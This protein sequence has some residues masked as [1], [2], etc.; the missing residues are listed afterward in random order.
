MTLF[1]PQATPRVFVLPPG[2]DF[3]QALLDGLH[4]RL[5]GHGPEAL[6]RVEILVNTR[7]TQRRLQA[8]YETGPARLLPR[9]SVVT[10]LATDPGLALDLDAAPVSKLHRHLEL[11]RLITAMIEADPSLAERSAAYDLAGA[12]AALMD[13][14]QAG[15]LSWEALDRIDPGAHSAHW[16]RNLRFLALIRPFLAQ[17]AD[18][19]ARQRA[20]VEA[21]IAAWQAAPPAH[22][23]LV[24]GSTGSRPPTAMLMEAVAD[25]PQGAVIL[26]GFDTDLPAPVWEALGDD[27]APAA[28]DH[29]QFGFAALAGRIGFS[30][31]DLPLWHDTAPPAPSRNRLIS[32]SLRPAPVTHQWLADGPALVPALPEATEGLSLIEAADPRDEARAIAMRLRLALDEG[33][34]AALVSPDRNLTRRVTA[35]LDRWR[36]TPDDSAGRPLSL[37]P[38]GVFLR[39]VLAFASEIPTP[40]DLLALLKHPLTAG[41]DRG[42]HLGLTRALELTHLRGG[43]PFIDWAD[44]RRWAETRAADLPGAPAWIAWLADSLAPL[45]DPSP[46][47]L[48]AHLEAHIATAE[49][50]SRGMEDATAATLWDKTA[51]EE[52]RKAI[53]ELREAADAS[54]TIPVSDY[55]TILTALLA[56][57]VPAEP[58]TAHEGIAIWGTLEARTQSAAL[59]ILGGLNEA[60]WPRLPDPDPWLNRDMR[61]LIGLSAP[62]RRVGLSAHD[63]QQALGAQEVVLSRALRDD[64]APTVASRWW[65]RLTNLL[66]GLG[67]EGEAA[68]AAMRGRGEAL[69]AR[70]ARLDAPEALVP[71]APR[72]AP[73]PPLAAR[74]TR[75]SVTRIETL[76]RDPYQIYA[77]FILRLKP[78]DPPGRAPDA[79]ARG[80][81]LHAVMERFSR[82]TIDGLTEEAFALFDSIA[83]ETLAAAAPWPATRRLWLARLSRIRDGFLAAEA[84]RR[85]DADLQAA[86]LEAEGYREIALPNGGF[87]LTAKA[88]RIDRMPDGRYRIYDYKSGN[89]SSAKQIRIYD[90]Q[91][92]LEAAIATAGGFK[93]LPPAPVAAM[94]LLSLAPDTRTV[95]LTSDDLD[96]D[97]VWD[98]F[99]QLLTAYS[100]AQ[101]GYAARLRPARI[102]YETNYD[103]L[104]RRGEW[105]DGDPITLIPVGGPE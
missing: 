11:T 99:R 15:G 56:R 67:P 57:E 40:V 26:P 73:S 34:P 7:R 91:L 65:L 70:A 95:T 43:A 101:T 33:R 47:P 41:T 81:A 19:E 50:L 104:S 12:L 38:P 96:S 35:F 79:L 46:R 31:T 14:M 32:L 80:T 89:L 23:V 68:L 25:L 59:V 36:V 69:R 37:T 29:P 85:N 94:T 21:R 45:A 22:P 17:A 55:R 76:T 77:R 72:P 13:E 58:I 1:S 52:A 84:E 30:T 66:T 61:R 10:D 86:G 63:F 53:A 82:A 28:T 103:Q 64:E 54:G 5:D 39:L 44:L 90:W 87:T 48:A 88:D 16:Q 71:P 97:R 100:N 78:L 92:P 6:A 105:A 20:A 8:L 83:A 102:K 2:V 27:E 24:A 74:P 75:L 42:P 51:G 4:A 93:D 62:E 18:A 98:E 3:G 9:L 60:T 49:A